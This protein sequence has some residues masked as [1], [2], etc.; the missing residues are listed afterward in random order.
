MP[1]ALFIAGHVWA[2]IALV[3]F[4]GCRVART[5]PTMYCFLDVE[6]AGW[7]DP[8]TYH[9]IVGLCVLASFVCFWLCFITWRRGG[10]RTEPRRGFEVG[11][12]PQQ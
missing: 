6:R 1:V 10:T 11:V 7:F 4:F 9:G 3:L 2:L 8:I 12:P 5:H